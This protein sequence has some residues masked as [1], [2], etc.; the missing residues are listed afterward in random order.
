VERMEIEKRFGMA[1]RNWRT[2][3]RIS[4]EDL[5]AKAG[6]QRTYISD[7]ERGTRNVSLKSVE[8]IADALRI[9]IWTLFSDFN[10]HPGAAPL[11][12]DE[13]VDILLVE[14][15]PEDAELTME[16]LKDGNITNRIYRVPDGAAALNFLFG[17]GEFSH[18]RPNDHPQVVLLDLHLP[19]IGGLEVLRRIKSDPRTSSIPVVVLT[20]SKDDRDVIESKRLGAETYIVKPVSLE[21]FSAMTLKLSMHWALFKPVT[22][23]GAPAS[24]SARV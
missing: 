23:A 8:K 16:A 14:D 1:V 5:A 9:S 6:L 18:R 2:R 4:Q 22:T 11:T 20:S 10:D 17:T 15:R 24:A 19:K 12:T 7:I 21:N 13:L 3:L